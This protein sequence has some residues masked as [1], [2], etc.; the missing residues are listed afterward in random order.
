MRF[1]HIIRFQNLLIIAGIQSILWFYILPKY[2]E[3]F[4]LDFPGFIL[5]VLASSFIAASGNVINDIFDL[6]I[7]NINKPKKVW[8]PHFISI[9]KAWM[10][11]FL[12]TSIGLG[13]GMGLSI[14]QSNFSLILWFLIPIILLYLYASQLK[15]ML[16]LNNILIAILSTYS[17]FLVFWLERN[18]LEIERIPLFPLI[19]LMAFLFIFSFNL[20]LLR[21]I[22]KDFED[23]IGDKAHS[24]NSLPIKFNPEISKKIMQIILF[25]SVGIIGG[26]SF[27]HWKDQPFFV[28][29]LVFGLG[30]S[31]FIFNRQLQFATQTKDFKKLAALLK[32]IM[33]IGFF[34]VFLIKF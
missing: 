23:V 14:I 18:A 16:F 25:G 7:D 6:E 3:Y 15:K 34:S 17:L 21:E 11:Y 8:I 20:S 29:Y 22:V 28:G 13:L 31:M 27:S 12:L 30:V 32:I 10:L 26:I 2:N 4:V 24:V 5:L 19:Q 33:L 1:F 9:K